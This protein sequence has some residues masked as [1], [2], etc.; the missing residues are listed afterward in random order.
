MRWLEAVIVAERARRLCDGF[1]GTLSSASNENG[2]LLVDRFTKA[3]YFTPD[4]V[5]DWQPHDEYAYEVDE[6]SP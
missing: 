5:W 2:K 4:G 1:D 3:S 6:P